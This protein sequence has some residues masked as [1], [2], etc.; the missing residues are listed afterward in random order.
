[1]SLLAKQYY[2]AGYDEKTNKIYIDHN[3]PWGGSIRDEN[4]VTLPAEEVKG[5]SIE[6][7]VKI[8]NMTLTII[9]EHSK[10]IK[11]YYGVQ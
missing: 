9:N 11:E 4:V 8:M 10:E 5:L 1:M 2:T 7:V 6:Q 3:E